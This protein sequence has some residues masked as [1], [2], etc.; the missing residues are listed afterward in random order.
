MNRHKNQE[1]S[2]SSHSS[3]EVC[4]TKEV[5]FFCSFGDE[6]SKTIEHI[7]KDSKYKAGETIYKAGS[8]PTGLYSIR[9]G[10]VKV[11]LLTSHGEVSIVNFFGA[12]GLLGYRS[13][14]KNEP[15]TTTVVAVEDCVVSFLPSN[16]IKKLFQC[17]KDLMLKLI[18]KLADDVKEAELKWLNQIH[19]SAPQRIAEAL[20]FLD[21]HFHDV[22]WS[23]KEIAEWA[24]T[25]SETV[26]RTL[27][28]FESEG[29]VKKGVKNFSI[30]NREALMKKSN[31]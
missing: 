26:I 13:F 17:H 29:I 2:P 14:F 4:P 31:P 30:L 16:E 1:T 28:I 18:S 19:K 6:I 9:K 5:G 10:V 22:N 8:H 27:S 24:G 21:D 12:G 7:K 11:E 3:C 20:L 25:T 15:H 23:R